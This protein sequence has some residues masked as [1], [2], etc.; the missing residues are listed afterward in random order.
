MSFIV[1]FQAARCADGEDCLPFEVVKHV[2]WTSNGRILE[3]M[4]LQ[5]PGALG[6]PGS[7]NVRRFRSGAGISSRSGAGQVAITGR[8]GCRGCVP[9]L[10]C[11]ARTMSSERM[12]PPLSLS[13]DTHKAAAMHQP[14]FYHAASQTQR[15]NLAPSQL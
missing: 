9:S 4:Y 2:I 12:W 5:C 15:A 6:Y 7:R 13:P 8:R 1:S 10:S 14:C 11:R 3:L